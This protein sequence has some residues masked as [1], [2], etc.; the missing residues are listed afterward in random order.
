MKIRVL[1]KPDENLWEVVAPHEMRDY[2]SRNRVRW[3]DKKQRWFTK[4][5]SVAH[6]VASPEFLEGYQHQLEHE[7]V[8]IA[9]SRAESCDIELPCP[10]KLSYRPF[11][12]AG[13]A[14][15]MQRSGTLLGDDMGLGKTVQVVGFINAETSVWKVLIFCPASLQTN[16]YKE[17]SKWLTRPLSI[18]VADSKGSPAGIFDI[19]ICSYSIAH[20]LRRDFET[21]QWDLIVC[22]EGHMLKNGDSQRSRAIFGRGAQKKTATSE[23]MQAIPPLSSR[24]RIVATGTPIPNR[25]MELW[26]LLHFIDPI[27]WNSKAEFQRRYASGNNLAELQR[28]LRATVMIR[29]M[30][31]DVLK[32]LPPKRRQVIEFPPDSATDAIAAELQEYEKRQQQ[33]NSLKIAAELAKASDDPAEYTRAVLALREHAI[34]AFTEISRVRHLTALRKLPYVIDHIQS[35]LESGKV[36]CFAHHSDV[37]GAIAKAFPHCAVVTGATPPLRRSDEA[38]RFQKDPRCKLFVGQLQAA[39]VGFTLT[40]ADTVIFAELDWVPG[41]IT[42]AEDRAARI[43]QTNSVLAQHLVLEGSLD[44]KMA[45]IVIEKQELIEAALDTEAMAKD[46]AVVA[47]IASTDGVSRSYITATAATLTPGQCVAIH[48]AVKIIA[49]DPSLSQ[50]DQGIANAIAPLTFID[51]RQAALGLHL[52]QKYQRSLPQ[53]LRDACLVN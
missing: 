35:C 18:A 27:I 24:Y 16:W 9:A 11:Q 1:H 37:L 15:A 22:D 20:V 32:E 7:A 28:R 6:L 53:S 21:V 50:I 52:V 51:M 29:R 10:A 34:Y 49:T 23:R 30:K 45:R 2:L 38:D 12:R 48:R 36:I 4:V 47:S 42:Q 44:A 46:E 41:V 33:L 14:Y 25:I 31:K 39:G 8:S 17:T 26:P 13:I 43:G 3:D 19:T 5:S 40:A